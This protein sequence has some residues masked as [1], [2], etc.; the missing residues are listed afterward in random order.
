MAAYLNP[1]NKFSGEERTLLRMKKNPEK[2]TLG[3]DEQPRKVVIFISHS[4]I[5]SNSEYGN[6]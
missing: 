1:H 2:I 5:D 6:R 4:I 3:N